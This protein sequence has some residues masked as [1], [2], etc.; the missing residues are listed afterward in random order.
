MST[1]RSG[2]SAPRAPRSSPPRDGPRP[3]SPV[4]E[5][6]C[7]KICNPKDPQEEWTCRCGYGYWDTTQNIFIPGDLVRNGQARTRADYRRHVT[8]CEHRLSG[9]PIVYRIFLG[10]QPYLGGASRHDGRH[11]A[12]SSRTL[13]PVAGGAGIRASVPQISQ[14]QQ[15]S[16][17][18]HRDAQ[19]Y[20]IPAS[21][22]NSAEDTS[23]E[24][25]YPPESDDLYGSPDSSNPRAVDSRHLH[26][27]S[28][29]YEDSGSRPTQRQPESNLSAGSEMRRP[30]AE[31]HTSQS[32]TAQSSTREEEREAS[33]TRREARHATSTSGPS[34]GGS[35]STQE[36]RS[37]HLANTS[38]NERSPSNSYGLSNIRIASYP[39]A[40][41]RPQYSAPI[42][43]RRGLPHSQTSTSARQPL[44]TD[45]PRDR[46]T[47]PRVSSS[48]LSNSPVPRYIPG[49]PVPTDEM[50]HSSPEQHL[51]VR[52]RP[53]V[54]TSSKEKKGGRR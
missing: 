28:F 29:P 35:A 4:C 52:S 8:H 13:P 20:E 50:P 16:E 18:R 43:D 3:P 51:P 42:S 14:W 41:S 26:D 30:G 21:Y 37:R 12:S 38:G 23:I 34:Y 1:S 49:E 54:K 48:N 24:Q 2:P 22:R 47:G 9:S 27:L 6:N 7:G 33:Q 45:Q 19:S 44:D 53:A 32:Y 17:N 40:P 15:A 5:A 25:S 39:L 31:R 11:N 36:T 46:D 10:T